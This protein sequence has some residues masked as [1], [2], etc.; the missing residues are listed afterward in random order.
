M[1][2]RTDTQFAPWHIIEGNDKDYARLKIMKT[3]VK[4]LKDFLKD[5]ELN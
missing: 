1:F 4:E 3:V 2:A 5:V